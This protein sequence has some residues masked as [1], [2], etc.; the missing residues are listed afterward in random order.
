MRE[1]PLLVSGEAREVG[2][3]SAICLLEKVYTSKARLLK[4]GIYIANS[5]K[6][7][8]IAKMNSCFKQYSKLN[9]KKNF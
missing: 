8:L 3:F 9:D 2:K 5:L 6:M 4:P 7:K 1:K